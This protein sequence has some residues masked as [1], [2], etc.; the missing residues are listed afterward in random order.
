M[1][2]NRETVTIDMMW[3]ADGFQ[4]GIHTIVARTQVTTGQIPDCITEK[5]TDSIFEP[6]MI[7]TYGLHSTTDCGIQTGKSLLERLKLL[8]V[9][10]E[11]RGT[12]FPVVLVCDDHSS[13]ED[14]DVMD[15]CEG[16]GKFKGSG[17]RIWLCTEPPAT[18]GHHQPLDQYNKKA[19]EAYKRGLKLWHAKYGETAHVDL[20]AFFEIVMGFWYDWSTADARRDSFRKCGI[21]HKLCPDQIDRSRWP[22]VCEAQALLSISDAQAPELFEV[23]E[24][25]HT[26][27]CSPTGSVAAQLE[28]WKALCSSQASVIVAL[29]ETPA[30]PTALLKAP[31]LK[32]EKRAREVIESEQ[33]SFFLRGVA[34]S[35]RAKTEAKEEKAKVSG[36]K[37]AARAAAAAVAATAKAAATAVWQQ[38]NGNKQHCMCRHGE[39]I[40]RVECAEGHGHLCGTCGD[41]KPSCCRMRACNLAT[42][43]AEIAQL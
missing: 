13:R 22:G 28:Y 2:G 21:S 25:E 36:E 24:P 7:S 43:P 38:H 5:I 10:L 26:E 39:D 35:K 12:Q 19:H 14:Q 9:E 1:Q 6:T 30:L 3:A 42:K 37:V 34:D 11:A 41:V 33:G 27:T 18:S 31:L 17:H 20:H 4:F 29:K 15:F 32:I 23:K 8:V 40:L 16:K